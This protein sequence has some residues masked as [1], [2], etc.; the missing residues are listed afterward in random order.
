VTAFRPYDIV[1]LVITPGGNPGDTVFIKLDASLRNQNSRND[2][3]DFFI[4]RDAVVPERSV[5]QWMGVNPV[6]GAVGSVTWVVQA[7]AG[8][9]ETFRLQMAAQPNSGS[10]ALLNSC[11]I[12]S[13]TGALSAITAPAGASGGPTLD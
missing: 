2:P 5:E 10:C 13:V 1:T 8:V 12:H 7:M 9:Q 4:A 6:Y 3:V 11:T